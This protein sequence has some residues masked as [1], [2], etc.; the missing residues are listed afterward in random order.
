MCVIRIIHI[1]IETFSSVDLARCGV[2]KYAEAPDFKILLFGYMLNGPP[3]HVVDL[4]AGEQIPQDIIDALTD[5]TVTKVAHNA[6]FERICLSRFLRDRGVLPGGAS[7]IDPAGWRCTMVLSAS[8]GL[9]MSLADVGSALGLDKQKLAEGK[10]LIRKFCVPQK[11]TKA[12]G[13]RTRILPEDNPEAWETFKAYN[14]RDVEV[15]LAI[16]QRLIKYDM[17]ASEW[18]LYELDQRINDRGVGID[19]VLVEQAIHLR[20]RAEAELTADLVTLTG[21][22]NPNSTA[23]LKAWLAEQGKTTASLDKE[24]VADLLAGSLPSDARTALELRAKLSKSSLAKYDAMRKAVCA[25]GR[26]RGS[27]MFYG[28]STTGRWAGRIVQPQN[29]PRTTM[30]AQDLDDAR[31]FVRR[32]D[33]DSISILYGDELDVLSQLIRT[34][35]A[36]AKGCK[37]LVSDYSAIEARVLA[38]LAGETWR[39]E[40]FKR[41]EDIYCASASQMFDVPVEKHGVNGH[42]RAKGKIAELALGYGGGVNAMVRMGALQNGL[43]EDELEPIVKKWRASSPHIVKLWYDLDDA[44]IEAVK[45]HHATTV[46]G[47]A[48]EY[49]SGVMWVTLPSGRKLAYSKTKVETNRFDRDCVSYLASKGDHVD[50]YGGKL[51][52]NITQAVARDVLAYALTNL[53]ARGFRVVCH[54]HDEVI[55]EAPMDA[56]VNTINDIMSLV[57]PWAKGLPLRAE[58]FE[59]AYYKKD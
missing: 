36:P 26:I 48:F 49:R 20:E 21:L 18:A 6:T 37:F 28:A 16:Y 45:W 50:L 22:E 47:I 59:S 17:P 11:P 39:L 34:A 54:V 13:G 15:E 29:L 58:G 53:D 40:A 52:E 32:G 42:L 27:L 30:T 10:E 9:P 3:V 12:N 14:L 2:Y 38:W 24:A 35:L 43:N 55:I 41:N 1:D 31:A 4:T 33:Y 23:Q 44:S 56:S 46:N 51:A 8:L 5:P 19:T 57:P 25:D 7:Y